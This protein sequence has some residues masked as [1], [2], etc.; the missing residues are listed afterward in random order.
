[1]LRRALANL[2]ANAVQYAEAPSCITLASMADGSG[3]T[4]TVSNTGPQIAPD[5]LARLFDRFYRADTARRGSAQSSGLGL[6]I[7]RMIM[8]MHRG[9]ATA[10]SSQGVN[11]F[12]LYFPAQ[13]NGQTA[14]S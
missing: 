4:L 5:Q 8:T 7:V 6:S 9:T 11:R 14:A 13:A 1:M 2:L 10:T 3:T 12:A